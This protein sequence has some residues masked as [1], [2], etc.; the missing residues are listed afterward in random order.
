MCHPTFVPFNDHEYP[1]HAGGVSKA[2]AG[3]AGLSDTPHAAAAQAVAMATI[4]V[5]ARRMYRLN[6]V[7]GTR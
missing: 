4:A 3:S 7:T 5:I 2:S 6:A 1:G